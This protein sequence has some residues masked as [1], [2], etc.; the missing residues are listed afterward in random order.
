[1]HQVNL[2]AAMAYLEN[3][4]LNYFAF[5]LVYTIEMFWTSVKL[6]LKVLQLNLDKGNN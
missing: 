5:L 1:M 4:I 3:L 2:Q 6:G